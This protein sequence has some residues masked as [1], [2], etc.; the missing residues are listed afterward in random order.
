MA[1]IRG[2]PP[3]VPG[4]IPPQGPPPGAGMRPGAPGFGPP[5]FG[6]R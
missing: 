6:Q 2:P 1:G 5:G 3:M 4:M